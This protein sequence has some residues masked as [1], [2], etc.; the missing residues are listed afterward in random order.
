MK[1]KIEKSILKGEINAPP[2]KSMAHRLLICAG[3]SEDESEIDNIAF[4]EDILA[5]LDCLY[6]MGAQIV[7]GESTVKIKGVSPSNITDSKS[8]AARESGSTL[9]FFIPI[10]LLSECEHSFTGYG[11]LMERP[12]EVYEKLCKE[13]GLHF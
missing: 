10:A 6:E 7:K 11:R 4:S 8:F 9:R 2:S 12:M 1:V 5:T 13:K 3:L